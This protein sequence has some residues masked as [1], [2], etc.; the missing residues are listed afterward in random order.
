[1]SIKEK[2]SDFLMINNLRA[3]YRVMSV[4]HLQQLQDK[5]DKLHKEKKISQ[6][7][8]L[9]H[10]IGKFKFAVPKDFPEAKSV[11]VL[12]V[13]CNLAKI[14]F[15]YKGKKYDVLLPGNY[16]ATSKT[17]KEEIDD[18]VL[19][20]I[21]GQSD[22]RV[23]QTRQLHLKFLTTSSGLGRY[24]RN[25]ISYVDELGSFIELYAIFTD[26]EFDEDHYVEAKMMDRC[27]KCTI[28]IDRC[29]N[30]C[31][32]RDNF[33][34]DVERCIPLYNEIRGEFPEWLVTDSHMA[35]MGCLHCQIPCPANHV[36][37]KNMRQF[38][39]ITEEE[40]EVLLNGEGDEE[41]ISTIFLKLQM[42]DAKHAD[43]FLPVLKRNLE[44]LLK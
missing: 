40:T 22:Y 38:E 41:V 26:Y 18:F 16:S 8:T 12:A 17:P 31:I 13:E 2:N 20:K 39:D 21:I 14:P 1:M 34:I 35:I 27:E 32:S 3:K 43:Y 11:I 33:I 44:V 10:Y 30:Q 42:F 15:H 19:E 28:C 7:E 23:Q 5:I 9:Q 37:L 36:A 4:K 25:N 24:G 29:P 6:H